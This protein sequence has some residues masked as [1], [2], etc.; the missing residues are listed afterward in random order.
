V[1]KV[2]IVTVSDLIKI[3][4]TKENR[5]GATGK[6]RMLN[7]SL[8]GIFAGSVEAV[9]LDGY[10]DGLV[11]DVTM[12]ITSFKFTTTNA[13]RIRNMSDEEL[14]ESNLCPHMVNWKRGNYGTCVHPNDK[15]AC[16]K[17][18]LDWLQSEAE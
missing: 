3:L 5:Y 17:C 2:K 14:A 18:M 8:N 12:E 11:A 15:D 9:K 4:D 13:D 10:G 6:P 7:L 1:R 16:K